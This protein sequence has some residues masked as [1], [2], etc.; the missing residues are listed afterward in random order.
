MAKGDTGLDIQQLQEKVLRLT[1]QNDRMLQEINQLKEQVEILIA[2][3][4]RGFK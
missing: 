3:S 4:Y 2:D 1:E